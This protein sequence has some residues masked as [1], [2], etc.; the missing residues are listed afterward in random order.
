MPANPLSDPNWAPDLAD[1]VTRIVGD[2]RDK[3]TNN[4]ILLARGLVFGILATIVGVAVLVLT[5]VMV[6]RGLQALLELGMSWPRAVY[7][8]Y[9]IVGGISCLAGMLLMRK[10]H[11]A[12]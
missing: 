3:T 2:I 1:T 8:S 7:V 11:T 9:F 5:V 10:R 6:M 4:L 12:S